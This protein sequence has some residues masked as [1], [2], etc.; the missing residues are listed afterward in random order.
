MGHL[1]DSVFVEVAN[2]FCFIIQPTLSTVNWKL[3]KKRQRIHC[4]N[5]VNM[6]A[7]SRADG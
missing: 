2:V 3:P 7:L 4:R 1:F 5:G 6:L